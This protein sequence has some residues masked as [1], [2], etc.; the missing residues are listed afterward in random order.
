MPKTFSIKQSSLFKNNYLFLD[1][2]KT[3]GHLEKTGI[4][5]PKIRGDMS[6]QQW[7]FIKS[8]GL[9]GTEIV[10][11][12]LDSDEVIATYHAPLFRQTGSLHINGTIYTFKVSSWRSRYTWTNKQD[13]NDDEPKPVVTFSMGGIFKRSG[14]AEVVDAALELPESQ[15]LL[16]LGLYLGTTAEEEAS[17]AASGG[18]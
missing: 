13:K 8:S 2:D 15:L 6:G 17:A 1:D 11:M 5:R 18:A 12:P 7:R 10:A 3:V 4:F 14:T 16:V 9:K